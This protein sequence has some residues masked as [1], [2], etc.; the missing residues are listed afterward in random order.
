VPTSKT[1]S[2]STAYSPEKFTT[3]KTTGKPAKNRRDPAFLSP[4][5]DSLAVLP[6]KTL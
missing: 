1:P 4:D 3:G 2:I 6:L 5:S